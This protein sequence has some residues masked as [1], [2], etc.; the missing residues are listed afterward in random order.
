LGRKASDFVHRVRVREEMGHGEASFE[1]PTEA[2]FCLEP[3]GSGVWM[4]VMCAGIAAIGVG[5]GAIIEAHQP[6]MPEGQIE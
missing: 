2:S 6:S 4:L 1:V 3:R 5:V